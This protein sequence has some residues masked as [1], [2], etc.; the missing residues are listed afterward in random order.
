MTW[1][2]TRWC[3]LT[4]SLIITIE[5]EDDENDDLEVGVNA[6][7]QEAEDALADSPQ[8]DTYDKGLL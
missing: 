7:D 4:L 6:T 5:A 1:V 3:H 2:A 8:T